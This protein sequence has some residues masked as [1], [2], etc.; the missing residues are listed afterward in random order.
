MDILLLLP[1]NLSKQKRPKKFFFG[2]LAFLE[3][4]LFL[5]RFQVVFRVNSNYIFEFTAELA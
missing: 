5:I 1:N 3:V 2:L 4:K